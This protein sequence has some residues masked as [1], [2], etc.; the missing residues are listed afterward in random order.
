MVTDCIRGEG[1]SAWNRIIDVSPDQVRKNPMPQ[2]CF[3]AQ[4]L[5]GR[6]LCRSGEMRRHDPQYGLLLSARTWRMDERIAPTVQGKIKICTG[7]SPSCAACESD[8]WRIM[9]QDFL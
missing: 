3:R 6:S 8:W 2:R 5:S 4:G 7:Q 9:C 1:G